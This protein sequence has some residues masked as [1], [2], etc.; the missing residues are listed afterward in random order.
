MSIDTS[1]GHP[2]MDYRAHNDT[3][4]GF[5]RLVQVSTGFLVILLILMAIFLV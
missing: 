3:Y 5:I 2:A 4:A 1:K